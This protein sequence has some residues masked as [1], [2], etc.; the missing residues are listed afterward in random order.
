MFCLT[1]LSALAQTAALTGQ[2][3]E[4]CILYTAL[5][6]YIRHLDVIVPPDAVTRTYRDWLGRLNQRVARASDRVTLLV[7]GIPVV[8]KPG[9]R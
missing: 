7:S 6:G 5:D 9:T 3:T 1:A 4:Q 2:V 8:I